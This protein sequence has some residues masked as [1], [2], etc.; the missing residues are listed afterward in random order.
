MSDAHKAALAAGRA[1]GRAVREYLEALRANKPKRGRKRTADSVRSQLAAVEAELAEAD[2]VRELQLVQKRMDLQSEL[3]NM[4]QAVDI[5]SLQD[6]FVKVAKSYS[7]RNHIS[8]G[9]W[10]E[11]GVDAAVLKSAGI[12]RGTG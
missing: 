12:G 11:V 8:Y 4:G 10:R 2:P 5:K 6:A 9:A 7:T 1:E 3:A